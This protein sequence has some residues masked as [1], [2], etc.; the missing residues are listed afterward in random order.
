MKHLLRL[1]I[2]VLA[3]AALLSEGSSHASTHTYYFN[4]PASMNDLLIFQRNGGGYRLSS[5]GSLND[6]EAADP[7][8]NGYFALTPAAYDR[9]GAIVFPDSDP[10][11]IIE[12]FKLHIH[13]LNRRF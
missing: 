12:G 7:S 1:G 6:P 3:V 2:G 8:T 4:A 13:L 11:Y 5:G 9:L 10:G